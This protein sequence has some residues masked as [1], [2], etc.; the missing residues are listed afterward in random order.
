MDTLKQ[1]IYNTLLFSDARF[2]KEIYQGIPENGYTKLI[3]NIIGDD[4]SIILDTNFF[5]FTI[6]IIYLLQL[7]T[8]ILGLDLL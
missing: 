8:N 7:R 1:R 5:L 2:Y 4:I 6:F 3:E